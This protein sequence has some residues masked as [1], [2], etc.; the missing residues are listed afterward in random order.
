V[1]QQIQVVQMVR[2]SADLELASVQ[3]FETYPWI[4]ICLII[5]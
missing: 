5:F 4:L 2:V 3:L 1:E